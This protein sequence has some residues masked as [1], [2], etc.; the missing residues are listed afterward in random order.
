MGEFNYIKP[1]VGYELSIRIGAVNNLLESGAGVVK[2]AH[3]VTDEEDKHAAFEGAAP[4]AKA[5]EAA[6]AATKPAMESF[7][8][9]GGGVFSGIE[10]TE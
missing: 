9:I 2:V 7:L 10:R 4:I 1:V 3:V 6:A 5:E 8:V